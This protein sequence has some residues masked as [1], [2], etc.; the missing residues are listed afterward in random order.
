MPH[1]P[2]AAQT[3]YLIAS[4]SYLSSTKTAFRK[5]TPT[6]I[7]KRAMTLFARDDIDGALALLDKALLIFPHSVTLLESRVAILSRI[8]AYDR[9]L[10]DLRV[11]VDRRKAKLRKKGYGFSCEENGLGRESRILISGFFYSGSGAVLDFLRSYAGVRKFPFVAGES[12][13]VKFPGGIA[14]MGEVVVKDGR[15]HPEEI[16]K[17]YLHLVGKQIVATKKGV[18]HKDLIVNRNNRRLLKNEPSL[19]YLY[20]ALLLLEDYW[21]LAR[22]KALDHD[23]FVAASR[24]GLARMLDAAAKQNKISKLVVDQIVTAWRIDIA[25]YMPPSSFII[26]HRD[27]RDQYA[28]V[29]AA[30]DQPGRPKWTAQQFAG[31]YRSWRTRV[32]GHIPILEGQHGHRVLRV[33]FEDFVLNHAAE[34]KRILAFAGIA[35]GSLK[36][37]RFFPDVSAA[38]VGKYSQLLTREEAECLETALPEYLHR[39]AR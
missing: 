33:G 28:E 17:F 13:V 20:Q 23:V 6:A 24:V 8:R 25:Q 15:L 32:D 12:R 39:P 16:A 37:Q 9:A 30:L 27:P 38:N 31:I 36:K 29:K 5:E 3:A 22:K 7:S 10:H 2:V 18:Y 11:A 14:E 19:G 34:A 35:A 4:V 26:V 21:A 1:R